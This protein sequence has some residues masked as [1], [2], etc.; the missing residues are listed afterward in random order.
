M[1][2]EGSGEPRS[3]GTPRRAE[4]DTDG[5]APVGREGSGDAV[6]DRLLDLVRWTAGDYLPEVLARSLVT[7]T[8]GL[9]GLGETEAVRRLEVAADAGRRAWSLAGLP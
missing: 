2:P 3:G 1:T 4:R 6:A 7:P 9:A 5:G 8:C